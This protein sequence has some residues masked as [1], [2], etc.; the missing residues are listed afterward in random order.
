MSAATKRRTV[1]LG[2]YQREIDSLHTQRDELA[3]AL[4]ATLPALILLGDFIGNTFDGTVGIEPFDRCEI[5]S[6]AR[7]ALSKVPR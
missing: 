5:I 4:R 6:Q 2:A 3:E 1:E 7:L